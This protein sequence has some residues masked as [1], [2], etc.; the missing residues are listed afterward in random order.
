M[1]GGDWEKKIEAEIGRRRADRRRG[2]IGKL[3]C[4]CSLLGL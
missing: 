4:V 2:T 3:E 1:R